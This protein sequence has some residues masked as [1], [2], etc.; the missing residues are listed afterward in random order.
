MQESAR[1]EESYLFIDGEYLRKI[2]VDAMQSVF[3]VDGDLHFERLRDEARCL[4]TFVYECPDEKRD[5]E[6]EA[7]FKVRTAPQEEY[8]SKI[9]SLRGFHL[10][11]GTLKGGKR[12]TQK[13][14]DVLLAVDM[15]SHGFNRNMSR[16]VLVAGDLDFRPIVEAL[17]RGGIFVEVWYDK[18]SAAKELPI[19]ADYGRELHWNELYMWSTDEFKASHRVPDSPAFVQDYLGFIQ[20]KKGLLDGRRCDLIQRGDFFLRVDTG[21]GIA[22]FQH[23]SP[24][25]L[26]RYYAKMW[27]PIEWD[28]Q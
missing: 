3:A 1:M 11:Q 21:K 27:K 24:D 22:W 25:V 17:I 14:V 13:E 7:D 28:S 23:K 20:V 4:K 26:E 18:R 15:L 2:Y 19:A 9:R 12:R 10:Q 6:S 16:A 5:G 8:F